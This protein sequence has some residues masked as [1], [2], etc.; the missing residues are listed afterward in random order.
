MNNRTTAGVL[1][2]CA[3]SIIGLY[4]YLSHDEKVIGSFSKKIKASTRQKS[5]G[6]IPGEPSNF[7]S[8]LITTLAEEDL[9]PQFSD[10]QIQLIDPLEDKEK[11]K[12]TLDSC[13][14]RNANSSNSLEIEVFN[15]EYEG[16]GGDVTIIQMSVFDEDKNKIL[17]VDHN[18]KTDFGT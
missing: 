12:A 14:V 1:L 15:S 10:I 9:T 11:I 8:N 2:I 3:A 4:L 16:E 5:S 7:C 17:E 6:F 18:W 13:L